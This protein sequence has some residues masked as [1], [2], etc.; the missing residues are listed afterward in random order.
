LSWSKED[1]MYCGFKRFLLLFL[2][3]PL[4]S[5]AQNDY[6]FQ[7]LTVE[8][9]LLSNPFVNAF[10]DS[11]GFYWF[12]TAN[13]IQRYGGKNFITY[14]YPAGRGEPKVHT[15]AYSLSGNNLDMNIPL[16][17]NEKTTITIQS[18]NSNSMVW[19]LLFMNKKTEITYTKSN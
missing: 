15:G 14:P 7:H 1:K 17:H 16:V 3:L 4:F 11:D 19:Q 9:G 10:Q 2:S 13:G 18:V 5:P 8:D 6:T 12:S